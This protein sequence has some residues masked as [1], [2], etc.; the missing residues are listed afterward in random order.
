MM[1]DVL[2]PES[3]VVREKPFAFTLM[4]D[5]CETTAWLCNQKNEKTGKFF[6]P[7]E[8]YHGFFNPLDETLQSFRNNEVNL[9]ERKEKWKNFITSGNKSFEREQDD[10]TMILGVLYM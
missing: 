1:S 7:N 8:P 4:S 9:E 5:G 2:V 10:K 3:V 6:D